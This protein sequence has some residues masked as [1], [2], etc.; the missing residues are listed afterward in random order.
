MPE[1]EHEIKIKAA[2]S[3]VF[4]ALTT[5]DGLTGWY[6]A[7]VESN[8]GGWAVTHTSKDDLKFAFEVTDSDSPSKVSWRCTTG[9]NQ[10]EGTVTTYQLSDTGDG[11]TLVELSHTEWPHTDGNYRMCNTR[12][13]IVLH[14]LKQY[15]ETGEKNP[16]Y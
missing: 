9:P 6:A 3:A 16:A 1:I 15:L 14:H 8:N 2:P 7:V 13:A 10:A 11:R 4:E 12:W 5:A